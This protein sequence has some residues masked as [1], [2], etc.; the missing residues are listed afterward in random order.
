MKAG[1]FDL[2]GVLVDTEGAYSIFWASMGNKFRPDVPSLASIIKGSTLENIYATYFPDPEVQ[3]WISAELEKHEREQRYE[4][5]R[6]VKPFLEKLEGAGIGCAI[7]TSSSPAKIGHLF[8]QHPDMKR[9]FGAII[10]DEDV[11]RSKPDPQGYNLAAERLGARPEDCVVFED[12]F[13]GLLAGKAAG[14]KVVALATTNPREA[15]AGKADLIVDDL[16]QVP[17]SIFG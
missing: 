4:F 11:T 17:L 5:F 6:E 14:G 8:E 2:D 3:K 12:S 16:G 13:N 10:T 1:L 7:V 15:L 9:Y